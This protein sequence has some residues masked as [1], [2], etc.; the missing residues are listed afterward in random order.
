MSIY[1]QLGQ[2]PQ[3]NFSELLSQIKQ[4]PA[5]VLKMAGINMPAGINDP[6]QLLQYVVNSNPRF[7]QRFQMIQNR[8]GMK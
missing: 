3:I 5:S 1:D 4:N 8:F 7:Q 6:N 2:R